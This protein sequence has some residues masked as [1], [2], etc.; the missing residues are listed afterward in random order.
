MWASFLLSIGGG[1]REGVQEYEGL[2]QTPQDKREVGRSVSSPLIARQLCSL[3]FGSSDLFIRRE[4]TSR[5]VQKEGVSNTTWSRKGP[6]PPDSEKGK[7]R[8]G[9]TPVVSNKDETRKSE[10]QQ[11]CLLHIAPLLRLA[12]GVMAGHWAPLCG[13]AAF[14]PGER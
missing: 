6:P 10:H 13:L 3:E 11:V 1:G 9:R 2:P 5:P 14:F 8:E 4:A 12:L 7:E